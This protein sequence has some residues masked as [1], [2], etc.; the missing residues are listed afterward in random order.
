MI[1][2]ISSR[3]YVDVCVLVV[4]VETVPTRVVVAGRGHSK[5]EEQNF[6]ADAVRLMSDVI[7]DTQEATLG[8]A[9]QDDADCAYTIGTARSSS[10]RSAAPAMPGSLI[11]SE[12]T[13]GCVLWKMFKNFTYGRADLYE[14]RHGKPSHY[15]LSILNCPSMFLH[16]DYRHNNR[17][18]A[19]PMK[20]T[21]E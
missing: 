21:V 19:T 20:L 9:M 15:L 7:E 12:S 11:I 6:D 14:I 18:S 13:Y 17:L 10:S 1:P 5:T 4:V 8:S 3:V 2:T 16:P